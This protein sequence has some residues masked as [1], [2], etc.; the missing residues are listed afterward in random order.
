MKIIALLIISLMAAIGFYYKKRLADGRSMGGAISN[1]KLFWLCF[2]MLIYFVFNPIFGFVVSA[3]DIMRKGLQILVC[4]MIGRAVL[5]SIGM[6]GIK[7]WSP[8]IGVALNVLGFIIAV[9]WLVK[10]QDTANNLW[11]QPTYILLLINAV[12]FALDAC[13]AWWFDVLVGR[14]TEGDTPIWYAS[15]DDP[16]FRA[17]NRLTFYSNIL[18]SIMFFYLFSTL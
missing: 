14:E 8:K 6:Y 11:Q 3:P 7:K 12:C 9:Y 5:Q 4:L 17:V 1:A 15:A 2:A 16:K 10:S 13:Y 18:L